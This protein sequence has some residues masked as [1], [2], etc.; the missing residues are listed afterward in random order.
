MNAQ[1]TYQNWLENPH[2]DENSKNELRSIAGQSAEIEDRFFQSL[3][4]GTAGLRGI[5]GVG[6]NRMNEYVVARTTQGYANYLLTQPDAARRGIAI[7]YDSRRKSREFAEIAASVL[8]ANGIH[9]FM[10]DTLHA[11]PQL[12][13]AIGYYQCMGGIVITASH[14]PADYNGYKVYGPNGA[15]ISPE[16]ASAITKQIESLLSYTE[17]KKIPLPDA[18][19]NHLLTLI[20]EEAD[21]AYYNYLKG[22][23]INPDAISIAKAFKVVYTPLNGTGNIPVRHI[24]HDLGI[25][26]VYVVAEQEHP[27][28]R[29]PTLEAPN[30]ELSSTYQLAQKLAEEK[31]ADLILATDPDADRLGVVVRDANQHYTILSGNQ[32]GYLLGHYILSQRALQSTLPSNALVIRSIVSG[33]MLDAIASGF[34]ATTH[35]VLTGFRYIGEQ[36]DQYAKTGEYTFQFGFEE[37]YGYLNGTKVRDKDAIGAVLLVIEVASHY[38]QKGLTL[39]E[40]LDTLYTQY[41][42]YQDTVKSFT[43]KGKDGMAD[44]QAAMQ[45]LRDDPPLRFGKYPIVCI[46]DYLSRKQHNPFT[47]EVLPIALPQSDVLYFEF[48]DRAW[49]CVRPSGTE[50][51]LKLYA[52]VLA[53]S[54]EQAQEKLAVLIQSLEVRLQPWLTI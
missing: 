14:N 3:Q 54:K 18:K 24:L 49:V 5:L 10:F 23:I 39:L 9:V 27:D 42:C 38:A 36:V 48:H 28:G 33:N 21:Q 6:T 15:Q 11:V 51:K 20:G 34:G 16:T 41:G 25:E 22:L 2:I 31:G 17:A 13:F 40:A 35:E 52:N 30:P 1:E 26:N 37:S 53:D 12:S 4:F 47:G 8:T 7:A 45:S 19:T 50:P 44:I 46:R 29:F 43:L 32:I